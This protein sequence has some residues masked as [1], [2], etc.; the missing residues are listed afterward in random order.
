MNRSQLRSMTISV[1]TAALRELSI[2]LTVIDVS[3]ND[4]T[5]QEFNVDKNHADRAPCSRNGN[6]EYDGK[7]RHEVQE[8]GSQTLHAERAP[9]WQE[10]GDWH[11]TQDRAAELGWC[12]AQQHTE[13]HRVGGDEW[14]K[15]TS[16]M[17]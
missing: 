11:R 1:D 10:Q 3:V 17:H 9:L 7:R 6:A 14:P 5:E 2:R 13:R 15:L 12:D 8:Q 16:E 4:S